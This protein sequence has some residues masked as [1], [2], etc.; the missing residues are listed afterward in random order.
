MKH[1]L[2]LP[3][4]F[5]ALDTAAYREHGPTFAVRWAE[6]TFAALE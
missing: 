2:E 1:D 6:K 5:D 3:T 4:P